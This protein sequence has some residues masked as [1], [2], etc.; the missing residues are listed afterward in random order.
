MTGKL[1]WVCCGLI[2][3]Y[4][5][6]DHQRQWSLILLIVLCLAV[7]LYCHIQVLWRLTGWTS[8]SLTNCL[9]RESVV[10]QWSYASLPHHTNE[11]ALDFSVVTAGTDMKFDLSG[12]DSESFLWAGWRAVPPQPD[13][14]S[15]P[16]RLSLW[17]EEIIGCLSRCD[18][19][20][21]CQRGIDPV[22]YH[23]PYA[24]CMASWPLCSLCGLVTCVLLVWPH[25]LYTVWVTVIVGRTGSNSRQLLFGV[26]DGVAH[27][28]GD[29]Q[30]RPERGGSR[31]SLHSDGNTLWHLPWPD[32]PS[33]NFM[34]CTVGP[35]I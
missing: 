19:A 18:T 15:R 6:R 28:T 23:P 17:S 9:W 33:I 24:P 34:S 27:H 14:H 32:N 22:I 3:V 21:G 1:V 5:T 29:Q 11:K 12:S 7:H 10:S 31:H 26:W 20:S 16:C 2:Q 4:V 25:D 13:W 30:D 8:R 35:D